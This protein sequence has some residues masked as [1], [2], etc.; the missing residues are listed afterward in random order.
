[1]THGDIRR[2]TADGPV[3][4]SLWDWSAFFR[5]RDLHRWRGDWKTQ[6]PE[7]LS[8]VWQPVCGSWE[9]LEDTLLA[10][11]GSVTQR[12]YPPE[13]APL[14]QCLVCKDRGIVRDVPCPI[15]SKPP[16]DVTPRKPTR[17]A[18]GGGE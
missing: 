7:P 17:Q 15:C 2:Y 12:W 4:A 14:W 3:T 1:M 9:T 5:V 13:T 16:V 10:R 6:Q 18:K 8:S 11:F